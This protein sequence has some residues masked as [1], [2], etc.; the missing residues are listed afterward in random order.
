M[1]LIDLATAKLH[2]RIDHADEDALL[3]IYI[4]AAE[5][6]V[7]SHLN[8]TVYATAGDVGSDT[9]GIVINGPIQAAMLLLIAHLYENREAVVG[10]RD[11]GNTVELPLGVMHLLQPYRIGLGVA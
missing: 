5:G 1:P 3:G 4:A 10:V 2:T 9:T 8:R 7:M 6:Q 11:A